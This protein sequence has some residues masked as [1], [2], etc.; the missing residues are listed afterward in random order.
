M[1]SHVGSF[2]EFGFPSTGRVLRW[3]DRARTRSLD[4]IDSI[5]QLLSIAVGPIL[6]AKGIISDEFPLCYLA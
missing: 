5:G 6:P 2:Q 1:Y 3:L 4:S